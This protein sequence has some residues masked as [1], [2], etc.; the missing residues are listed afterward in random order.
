MKR[1][2]KIKLIIAAAIVSAAVLAAGRLF[3]KAA[4][5]GSG[6]V[7][8]YLCSSTFISGRDPAIGFETDEFI[9]SVLASLP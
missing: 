9:K 2:I 6:F 7:A 3:S 4:P 8:K 5:I 1:G